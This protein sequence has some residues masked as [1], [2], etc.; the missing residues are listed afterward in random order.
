MR[1]SYILLQRTGFIS[2][3]FCSKNFKLHLLWNITSAVI[4]KYKLRYTWCFSLNT[5]RLR[6]VNSQFFFKEHS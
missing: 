4:S 2:N 6:Q 3:N 5:L 1:Y